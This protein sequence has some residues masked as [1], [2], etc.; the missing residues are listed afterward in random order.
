MTIDR[1]CWDLENDGEFE[2]R[3]ARIE[4]GPMTN[5]PHRQHATSLMIFSADRLSF[6]FGR[7]TGRCRQPP[8]HKEY[9]NRACLM[10]LTECTSP[11]V[12]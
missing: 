5:V 1:Q 2:T 8:R 10:G 3:P 6:E 7:I 12:G 9:S 4:R 11:V